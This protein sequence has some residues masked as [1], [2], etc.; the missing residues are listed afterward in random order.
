MAGAIRGRAREI[1]AGYI[2]VRRAG[3]DCPTKILEIIAD[4]REVRSN[5]AGWRLQL[6]RNTVNRRAAKS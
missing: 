4:T 5:G 3:C 1:H 2:T 6:P